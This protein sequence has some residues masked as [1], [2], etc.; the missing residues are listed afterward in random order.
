[1]TVVP[2]HPWK[3]KLLTVE[4]EHFHACI[5]YY[6]LVSARDFFVRI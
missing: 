3:R 2:M 4:K 1:M 6:T 5:K